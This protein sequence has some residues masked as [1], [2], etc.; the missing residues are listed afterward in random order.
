MDVLMLRRQGLTISEIARELGYHPAT[1]SAWLA[2]GGPAPRRRPQAPAVVD[3]RWAERIAELL[4]RSPRLLATSVFEILVAEGFEGSY[5]TVARHLNG[6]RGPRFRAAKTASVRIETAPGEECQFDFSDVSAWTVGWG[7]G[8]VFCFQAVLCWSRWRTWWFTAS[9]DREHTFEGLVR[10]FEA[11]G[12]VPRVA[13]TDRMG[14]LGASQGRRFKLHLPT[15][16]FA[17]AHGVEIRAC[18]AG[19]AA[20]KGKVERPFRDAKERFLTEL[21]ALEPPTSL[22]ELNDRGERWLTERIHSRPHRTTGVAP[23]QRLAAERRLL[24][25]LPRRR[26]DTAY[27]E[28]RRVHVAVPMIEWRRVRYSVPVACL[29]QRVE[30]RQDVDTDLVEIRWA[31]DVVARH[32]V[33]NGEVREVWDGEHFAAAQTAALGKHRRHLHVVR[34]HHQPVVVPRLE[35]G[36]DYDVEPID[37]GRYVPDGPHPCIDHEPRGGSEGH[38]EDGFVG[39]ER[40]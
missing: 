17:Q 13:R 25:R 16:A 15:V 5:P 4:R 33:P 18:Q 11:A 29:G 36:G 26:Y 2:G 35:L 19:D 8:E 1:I 24:G 6:V 12:G 22:A 40:Q 20:R 31:G 34:D 23:A 10:F 37:L 39:G 28:A 3:E 21:V 30:V 27:V 38:T 7:L 32:R 9:Q 14:A